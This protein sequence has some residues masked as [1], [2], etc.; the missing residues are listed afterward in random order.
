MNQIINTLRKKI[1]PHTYGDQFMIDAI[2]YES[3]NTHIYLVIY[4]SI[5]DVRQADQIAT[6]I[7]SHDTLA[8]IQVC[9][10]TDNLYEKVLLPMISGLVITIN[11]TLSYSSSIHLKNNRS[12]KLY[13]VW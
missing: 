13:S 9:C 11:L 5:K 10:S 1:F 12:I 3:A 2:N 4:K 8:N 6:F 7:S